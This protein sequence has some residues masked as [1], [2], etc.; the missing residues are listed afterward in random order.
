[1]IEGE[2]VDKNTAGKSNS[3]ARILV[4][5]DEEVVHIS[6]QRILGRKG[7][8]VD[9]VLTA[10][11]GIDRLCNESYDMVITDLMMPEMNGIELLQ[12]LN[13]L[14]I[15]LPVLMVTG[16]PTIKTALQALRLGAVD[17]LAK[18]FTRTELLAPVNRALFA[19]FDDEGSDVT[20][21]L[22]SAEPALEPTETTELQPGDR[23][24][25]RRHSWFEYRQ[26]GL[27]N[28]GIDPLFLGSIG[29]VESVQLPS[30]SELV[31]QGYVGIRLVTTNGGEHGVLMP[32]SGKVVAIN[33]EAEADAATISH[34]TWLVRVLP[35]RLQSEL[36]VLIKGQG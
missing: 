5:D 23:Y 15:K 3:G 35:D 36:S 32:L 20:D 29:G 31:E 7:H 11:D 9:G 17:Y 19:S 18:P 1:M 30:E 10:R 13:K 27:V 21:E 14:S 33:T 25:L 24:G 22:L 12:Q 16:Y 26:D 8:S 34:Q 28:V 2:Q 4:I 6:L